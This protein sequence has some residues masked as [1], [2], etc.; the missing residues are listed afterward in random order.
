[1]KNK[2][3]ISVNIPDDVLKHIDRIAEAYGDSREAVVNKCLRAAI[4]GI[5]A[6]SKTTP[7]ASLK[8][9]RLDDIMQ[10]NLKSK[11]GTFDSDS[12]AFEEN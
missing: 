11:A 7:D 10:S 4:P 1:M 3:Q 6:F 5:I 9:N 12:T 2:N 8:N